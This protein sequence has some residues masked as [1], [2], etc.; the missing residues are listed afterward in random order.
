[1]DLVDIREEEET[2][3]DADYEVNLYEGVEFAEVEGE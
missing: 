2:N 3:D 1:M